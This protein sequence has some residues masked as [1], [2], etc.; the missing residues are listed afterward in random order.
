MVHTHL[1]ERLCICQVGGEGE[2]Q[3]PQPLRLA[4]LQP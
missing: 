4:G 1:Q 3:P 2:G